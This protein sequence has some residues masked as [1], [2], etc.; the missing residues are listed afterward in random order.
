MTYHKLG[1]AI[2]TIMFTFKE[3]HGDNVGR[4]P[5]EPVSFR[6]VRRIWVYFA[7]ERFF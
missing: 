5:N 7:T 2:L 1:L 4:I 6:S 3:P